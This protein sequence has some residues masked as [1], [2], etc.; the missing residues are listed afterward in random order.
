MFFVFV[1]LIMMMLGFSVFGLLVGFLQLIM[2]VVLLMVGYVCGGMLML[3]LMYLYLL[4]DVLSMISLWLLCRFGK[5]CIVVCV[6]V[7]VLY[8]S[9]VC[10]FVL[11]EVLMMWLFFDQLVLLQV[12]VVFGFVV[13]IKCV[14]FSVVCGV[15]FMM[16][17]LFCVVVMMLV[18]LVL[19]VFLM[20]VGM[21]VG[22]GL[23]EL[24]LK[25]CVMFELVLVNRFLLCML[26]LLFSMS[27]LMFWFLMLVLCVFFML[28]LVVL[29]VI[30]LN[31]VKKL[32]VCLSVY[33]QVYSG[34]VLL[35]WQ[36][37]LVLM[38]VFVY[39]DV[40]GVLLFVLLLLLVVLLFEFLL[41]YVVRVMVVNSVKVSVFFVMFFMRFL[42]CCCVLCKVWDVCIVLI[43]L[44]KRGYV[45]CVC[46]E[47][48]GVYQV[49]LDVCMYV[50]GDLMVKVVVFVN[51]FGCCVNLL[52]CFS[53]WGG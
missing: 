22:V 27:M 42:F 35:V 4:F 10:G 36:V 15:I 31:V 11:Y 17:L 28:M 24:L 39:V 53:F 9:G 21:F 14:L 26:M 18:M 1:V 32:V 2:L 3:L 6:E 44:M 48:V 20:F 41:L 47:S 5:V 29:L 49:G 13:L 43:C 51:W 12:V 33:W 23:F 46:C 25:L 52:V 7:D 45:V 8:F 16:F 30:R 19:C 38:L 40:G 34:L 37:Y 50:S